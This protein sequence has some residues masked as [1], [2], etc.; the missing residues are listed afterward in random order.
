MFKVVIIGG[1]AAGCKAAARLSRISSGYQID[2]IERKPFISFA[3]CGLPI[4]ASG[5]IDNI[6]DL[7]K[8]AYGSIRDADYFLNVKGVKIHTETE[9]E[10]INTEEKTV[11]CCSVRNGEKF[12]LPYDALVIATGSIPNKPLFPVAESKRI[13]TFYS[14][15][16][17]INFREE[18][19]KGSINKVVIIGG[20]FIGCELTESMNTLWGIDTTIIEKEDS[21]LPK[22][23]DRE[24]SKLVENRLGKNSVKIHLSADVIKIDLNTAALPVVYLSDGSK[25]ECDYVF[26]NVGIK[27][28]TRLAKQIGVQ[29]G[30]FGG[31][32]VD[33]QM[34]TN[35]ENIWA[36]GDCVEI[37]NLITNKSDFFTLGSLSNRM[38]RT[39]ADSISGNYS[40]FG[41]A[42]GTI[43][44][45]VFDLIISVSGLTETKAAEM[46]YN[47]GSVIGCWSD[48]PDFHPDAKNLFGKIVYEKNSLKLLGLQM[49]GEGEVNRYADV[50][51]ELSASHRTAFD[52]INL[53]HGYTP[54]HSSPLSP[55][56]YFGYMIINQEKDKVKNYNPLN[57]SSFK[58]TLIDIREEF[59]NAST[60]FN[61]NSEKIPLSKFRAKIGEINNQTP[62][63]VV[64]EKGARSYE[65]TKILMNYGHSNA[66]YLGGGAFLYN[67][68]NN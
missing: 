14:P 57:L 5:E 65:A 54:A 41:G 51:S 40:K 32:I 37:K 19:Q 43:S 21:L 28:N 24:F 23:L 46:G 1:M 20:G 36:A 4:Y 8:T 13:S 55:L 52:L 12:S 34:K 9:A 38:G 63:V 50:F 29:C 10:I 42:V 18:V 47:T 59:E 67:E 11:V 7:A 62:V 17:A 25:I 16:D 58:G 2:V 35:I 3:N 33:D 31:I 66:S 45:K 39:A 61:L 26:Y 60:P 30:N 44:L 22:I 53:E 64:C 68:L 15:I 27:P 49:L 6:F 56:N 48:R